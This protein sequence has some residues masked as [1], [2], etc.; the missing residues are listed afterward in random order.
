MFRSHISNLNAKAG[1]PAGLIRKPAPSASV[2]LVVLQVIDVV[3]YYVVNDHVVN[4]HVVD[5]H[6]VRQAGRGIGEA[7]DHAGRRVCDGRT[8]IGG[9]ELGDRV[10]DRIRRGAGGRR[11]TSG[12]ADIRGRWGVARRAAYGGSR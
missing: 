10:V 8:G 2:V 6:V 7:V 12:A 3:S 9:V 5:D 11:G 1:P 4:D